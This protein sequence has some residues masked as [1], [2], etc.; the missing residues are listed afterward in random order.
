MPNESKLLKKF[1]NM[2]LAIFDLKP[3]ID[4]TLLEDTQPIWLSDSQNSL[5]EFY[6]TDVIP[7]SENLT[8]KLV[9][10]QNELVEEVPEM[11]NVFDSMEQKAN[12]K[13]S[14]EQS[15][16]NEIDRLL[17]VS[18][19]SDVQYC[20]LISSLQHENELLVSKKDKIILDSKETQAVMNQ[21]IKI[22]EFDFQRKEAHAIKIELKNKTLKEQMACDVPWNNKATELAKEK[23][24]L[25]G[26]VDSYIQECER[27]KLEFQNLFNSIKVTRLQHQQE[28]ASLVESYNQK[29]YAFGDVRAQNQ[30]LLM[31]ISELKENI[32][33]LE[34]AYDVNTRIDK[35]DI[36]GKPVCVT[37][38]PNNSKVV[39]DKSK[40]VT[41]YST[42]KLEHTPITSQNVIARGMYRITDI[43]TQMRNSKTNKHSYNSTGVEC[44]NSAKI[45]L[46]KDTK[47][48]NNVLKN[49][50]NQSS[51]TF[52]RKK[53][54]SVSLASNKRETLNTYV[55]LTNESVKN[56]T[57]VNSVKDGSRYVC[58]SCGN[59]VFLHSHEKCV[60]RYALSNDFSVKRALFTSPVT[61]KSKS[62]GTTR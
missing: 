51:S 2:H 39:K 14:N 36:L 20:V 50:K 29:T 61:P 42:S 55:C 13:Y 18:L 5:R 15:F 28:V 37:P 12:G 7:M 22:L 62:L 41:S 56:T 27:A 8:K 43:D 9:D 19:T 1:E 10:L 26:Q 54:S 58:V 47:M 11:K 30:E 24:V 57:L 52:A 46:T 45:Q 4:K 3:R 23:V 44:S 32:Q 35:S 17:E 31:I 6:K 25:K 59:D 34:N 21:Q 40:Q 16:Q 38:M 48:K 60:V 49:T 33:K 53:S